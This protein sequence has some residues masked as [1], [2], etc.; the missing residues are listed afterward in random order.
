M[1]AKMPAAS[2]KKD[3]KGSKKVD[4]PVKVEEEE[5]S[6]GKENRMN[7]AAEEEEEVEVE[8][9]EEEV[10]KGSKKKRGAAARAESRPK[11][12]RIQVGGRGKIIFRK[13]TLKP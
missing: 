13:C 10:A 1:F 3:P 6:P 2:K 7:E 12:K 8:E 9:K 5:T 4:K 11:R